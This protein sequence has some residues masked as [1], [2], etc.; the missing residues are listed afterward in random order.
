MFL[1]RGRG[2]LAPPGGGMAGVYVHVLVVTAI[3]TILDYIKSFGEDAIS[4][5]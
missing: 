5:I 4:S 3:D 1:L 2:G